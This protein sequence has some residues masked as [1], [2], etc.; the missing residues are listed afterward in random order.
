MQA[1]FHQA[2]FGQPDLVSLDSY[3][4]VLVVCRIRSITCLLRFE[5]WLAKMLSITKKVIVCLVQVHLCIGKSKAVNFLQPR[6]IFLILCGSI[7]QF[8]A[9]FFVVVK[10]VSKHLVIDKSDT[11]ESLGK[12]NLLF[13]RWVESISVCLIHY[14]LTCLDFLCIS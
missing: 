8:L 1:Q 11:A 10:A 6:K 13:R 9:C 2:Y 12:H 7:V 3:R 14:N 5:A 4:T